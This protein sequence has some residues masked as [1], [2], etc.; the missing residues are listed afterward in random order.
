MDVDSSSSCLND[1]Q[2]VSMRLDE[3]SLQI[4]YCIS[5]ASYDRALT[6][7]TYYEMALAEEFG[8][9][10]LSGPSAGALSE[11]NF[12]LLQ[13][14]YTVY[15]ALFLIVDDLEGARHLWRRAPA[16][17]T[18]D[19][20]GPFSR[21]WGVGKCLYKQDVANAYRL[22]GAAPWPS[23]VDAI[24]SVLRQAICDRA[25]LV[26]SK[27]YKKVS[28]STLAS[29]GGFTSTEE[30]LEACKVLGWCAD[31]SQEGYVVV[32]PLTNG[33]V[34]SSELKNHMKLM[35][36]L[37]SYVSGFEKK[38]FKVEITKMSA[39]KGSSNMEEVEVL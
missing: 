27:A 6:A 4:Q 2:Y 17:L 14:F 37:T 19:S 20:V 39:S 28:V 5:T 10:E 7:C 32:A 26:L 36:S 34:T 12:V 29:Y 35:Q 23:D 18:S 21:S 16:E 24:V 3:M 38:Q 33:A 8:L 22:L 11:A 15:M 9:K 13:G 1:A 30:A 31:P 25:L